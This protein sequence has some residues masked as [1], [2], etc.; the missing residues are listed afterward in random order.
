LNTFNIGL[1]HIRLLQ[2]GQ[3]E[4]VLLDGSPFLGSI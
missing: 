4:S 3:N 2:Y 1:V